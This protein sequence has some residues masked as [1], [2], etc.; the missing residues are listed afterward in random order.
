AGR[1]ANRRGFGGGPGRAAIKR[2]VPPA[3]TAEP[4]ERLHLVLWVWRRRQRRDQIVRRRRGRGDGGRGRGHRRWRCRLFELLAQGG[5]AALS[6]GVVSFEVEDR[7][8]QAGDELGK[9]D[10]F[11]VAVTNSA[12]PLDHPREQ[13]LAGCQH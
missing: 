7:A 1:G 8:A 12:L 9:V 5:L 3:W 13:R 4:E 6:Q 2:V 10:G 11:G